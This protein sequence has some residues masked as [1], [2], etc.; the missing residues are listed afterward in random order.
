MVTKVASQ[1]S[2]KVGKTGEERRRSSGTQKAAAGSSKAAVAAE[3]DEKIT[4]TASLPLGKALASTEKSIRDDAIRSLAAYL[5]QADALNA[6]P[7]SDLEMAK[8]WKG[9]FYCF[10]MSDK[11]RVQ[12]ALANEMAEIPLSI[13][14]SLKNQQQISNTAWQF[15]EGFLDS[16][17]RE[18][19]G[20]DK[21]RVDK[22]MMLV[23][24]F[25]NAGFRLLDLQGYEKE[26]VERFA[27]M[28]IKPGGILQA[29]DVKT[30]NGLMYH[31]CDIYL[32]EL[33]KAL[34]MEAEE[35][36][37]TKTVPITSLL[38]PFIDMAAA[39]HASQHFDRM[40]KAVIVPYL[41]DCLVS[42][43]EQNAR[44][45]VDRASKRQKRSTD[46]GSQC[47]YPNI[48][49]RANASA[50]ELR[51]QVF[52]ELFDVASRAES[53]EARR[54]RIYKMCREE[55]ERLEDEE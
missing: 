27:T 55:E 53:V 19:W 17:V 21:W 32:E 28:L 24:R 35:E 1:S 5:S 9:I 7:L 12:Q 8:L 46:G 14:K 20:L 18:W 41:D 43:T 33:D 4:E 42:E 13:Q 37:D 22:F 38:K 3:E 49:K 36:D 50:T 25:I 16:M 2:R 30:P 34:S 15:F 44:N 39:C 45:N 6:E 10:W 23:R 48:F 31:V 40:L 47:E 52:S 54:R 51:S 26:S 11:P 29:N